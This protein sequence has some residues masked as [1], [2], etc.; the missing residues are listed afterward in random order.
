MDEYEWVIYLRENALDMYT[1]YKE[2]SAKDFK[3]WYDRER[4]DLLEIKVLKDRIQLAAAMLKE[5]IG[6][7]NPGEV[8]YY[9]H[10]VIHALHILMGDKGKY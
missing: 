4:K 3:K 9:K 5:H 6:D 8:N 2:T 10:P 7:M 1:L